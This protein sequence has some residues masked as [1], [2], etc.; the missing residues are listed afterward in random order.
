MRCHTIVEANV[1]K[2]PTRAKAL[3]AGKT[4]LRSRSVGSW[5][6]GGGGI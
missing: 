2:G 3:A 5:L 4:N 1:S 6:S